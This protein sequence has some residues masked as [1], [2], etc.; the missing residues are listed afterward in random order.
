MSYPVYKVLDIKKLPGC[1]DKKLSPTHEFLMKQAQEVALL[2]PV[3]E[4]CS[5][6]MSEVLTLQQQ[7]RV[8]FPVLGRMVKTTPVQKFEVKDSIMTV[9]TEKTR[10][11]L[12]EERIN[13]HAVEQ[14]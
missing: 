7:E 10:Y 5:M 1:E 8:W 2:H 6:V 3:K 14:K 4:G 12:K 11:T 9:D 13:G